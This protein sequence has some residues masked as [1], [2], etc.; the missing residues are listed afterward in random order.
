MW[1]IHCFQLVQSTFPTS[2]NVGDIQAFRPATFPSLM[3][4]SMQQE[5]PFPTA[6]FVSKHPRPR[7]AYLLHAARRQRA[8]AE[9][10]SS[11]SIFNPRSKASHSNTNKKALRRSRSSHRATL[12][13]VLLGHRG[14]ARHLAADRI[15][16]SNRCMEGGTGE[17]AAFRSPRKNMEIVSNSALVVNAI[18][19]QDSLFVT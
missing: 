1:Y 17:D 12:T 6:R 18:F 9:C 13:V 3:T 4:E 5:T 2:R 16:R 11:L 19:K 14:K 10:G 15:A 8:D 7:T